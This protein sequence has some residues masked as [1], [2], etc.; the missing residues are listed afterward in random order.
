ME[1]E[2][3]ENFANKMFKSLFKLEVL[4]WIKS[5]FELHKKLKQREND[6]VFSI[7][8]HSISGDCF[9]F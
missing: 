6:E 8:F 2:K 7:I 3:V 9:I 5:Y 4:N 1:R